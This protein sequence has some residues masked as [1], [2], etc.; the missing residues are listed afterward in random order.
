MARP[1]RLCLPGHS[2]LLL[3]RA[4]TTAF[5]TEADYAAYR[6]RLFDAAPRRGVQVQAW[7][8]LPDAVWLLLCPADCAGMSGLMQ[9]LAREA[10]RRRAAARGTAPLWAGR[11]RGAVLQPGAVALDALCAVDAAAQAEGLVDAAG[12]WPWSSLAAHSGGDGRALPASPEYWALGNTPFER[13]AAYRALVA[14]GRGLGA[15]ARL[16]AAAASGLAV[17]DASFVTA[18]ETAAGRVLRPRR[19]GRPALAA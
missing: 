5:A 10:S 16:R 6:D 1:N 11:F 14:A 2:H 13:E 17:G 8:L 19:R 7:C 9:E 15:W 4:T 18:A 3:Q 12:D